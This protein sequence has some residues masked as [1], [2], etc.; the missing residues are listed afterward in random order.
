MLQ[1]PARFSI[2]NLFKFLF[3]IQNFIWVPTALIKIICWISWRLILIQGF[4]H[5]C[6]INWGHFMIHTVCKKWIW[7]WLKHCGWFVYTLRLQ[8]DTFSQEASHIIALH[9]YNTSYLS[10]NFKCIFLLYFHW[11][12]TGKKSRFEIFT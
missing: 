10:E 12:S 4:V 1:I 6:L 8:S 7:P 9:N 5:Y 3:Y 2:L 11:S